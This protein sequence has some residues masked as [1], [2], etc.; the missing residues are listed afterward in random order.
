MQ[1]YELIKFREQIGAALE[2]YFMV[3]IYSQY[4]FM[5]EVQANPVAR[6]GQAYP[7]Q[8]YPAQSYPQQR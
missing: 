1:M 2:A 6:P 8:G 7:A 4:K 3:V 5:T